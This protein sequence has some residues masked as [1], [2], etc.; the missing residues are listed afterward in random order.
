MSFSQQRE[1]EKS[2]PCANF[3]KNSP[4]GTRLICVLDHS[5]TLVFRDVIKI[6]I[7]QVTVLRTLTF[8]FPRTC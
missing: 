7:L 8:R 5:K 6:E 3:Q 2:Y 4:Y 1:K